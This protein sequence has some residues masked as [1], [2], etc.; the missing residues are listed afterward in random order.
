MGKLRSNRVADPHVSSIL[1][2]FR[3]PQFVGVNKIFPIV[4]VKSE[5]GKFMQFAADAS[6]VRQNL[7]RALG[8]RRSRIEMKVGA[9]TYGTTESGIE[10]PLFDRELKNVPD[11]LHDAYRMKK[12]ELAQQTQLLLME[13]TVAQ[14]L[15]NSANYDGAYTTALA[16]V[17]QWKDPGSV[18]YTNLRSWLRSVKAS[19][20]IPVDQ[21]SIAF[22]PKPLEALQEHADTRDR[23]KYVGKDAD[24]GYLATA[25]RCK[26]CVELTGN[27]ASAFNPDDPTDVTFTD[28]YDDEVIVYYEVPN[29]TP[30]VIDPLWGGVARVDGY[31]IETEYRDEPVSADV[32]AVDEN[33]GVFRLSNKRGFLG[34]TVSGL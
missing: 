3:V 8:D 15:K 26:E 13:Y 18:P 4:R 31:P 23:V 28:I 27:Y 24:L 16:G 17:N 33:W 2:G 30:S 12:A 9:G 21:L 14:I 19:T 32:I 34:R 1:S 25:L 29:E 6:V 7:Q 11:D 5:A 22:A 10:V 20:G